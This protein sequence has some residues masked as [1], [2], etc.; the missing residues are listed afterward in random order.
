MQE[1]T[2]A[3]TWAH[4][5]G[6]ADQFFAIQRLRI[7]AGNRASAVDRGTDNADAAFWRPWEE[8][9]RALEELATEDLTDEASIHPAYEPLQQVKGM[10]PVLTA[11][12]LGCLG[13]FARFATVSKLWAYSGF[14]PD[15]G[16]TKGKFHNYNHTL[17]GV[18]GRIS[19]RMMMGRGP[20]YDVYL[21][22]RAHYDKTHPEWTKGHQHNASLRRMLKLFLSHAWEIGRLAEGLPIVEPWILEQRGHTQKRP[23][24]DFYKNA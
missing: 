4:L 11:Q 2:Q 19:T 23:R 3:K 12:L 1:V 22:S 24:Q 9:W 17:K 15:Q 14:R 5:R 6:A 18:C 13:T 16:R 21:D 7:Q 10:G 8:R 20:Y